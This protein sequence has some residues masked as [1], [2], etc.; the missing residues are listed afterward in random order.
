MSQAP[1][2]VILEGWCIGVPAQTAAQLRIPANE[3][4]RSGDAD[5]RWRN[6]VNARLEAEYTHVWRQLDRL[7]MLQAPGFDVVRRWRD[8][9]EQALRRRKAP[10]ALSVTALQR[11]LDHIEKHD[12]VWVSR[13]IDLA[14]HWKTAHPFN[15][16]DALAWERT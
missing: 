10:H 13:R 4:E 16:D 1:G 11:F 9:Q 8:E 6:W 2:L 14:R 15:P 12:R 5:A 3:L 7:V